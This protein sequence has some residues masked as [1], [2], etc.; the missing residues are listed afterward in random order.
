MWLHIIP[1]ISQHVF[2]A[3]ICVTLQITGA[4]IASPPILNVCTS[5]YLKG[6]NIFVIRCVDESNGR[7]E[8]MTFLTVGLSSLWTFHCLEM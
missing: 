6:A 7:G 3:N 2:C 8:N 1:Q 5:R 4:V